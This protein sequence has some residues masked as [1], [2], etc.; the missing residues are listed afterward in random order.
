MTQMAEHIR[1]ACR[2]GFRIDDDTWRYLENTLPDPTPSAVAAI[3]DDAED[4]ESHSLLE[5]LFFPDE[6]M[7]LYVE[8][9]IE[10]TAMTLQ[11]QSDLIDL[12]A[13]EP[14][15]T[16]LYFQAHEKTIYL[17]MPESA[18]PQFVIRL[19]LTYRLHPQLIQSIEQFLPESIGNQ[20]KVRLRNADTAFSAPQANLLAEIFRVLNHRLPDY[21]QCIE[22]ML[23]ILPEM[24][25]QTSAYDF[26]MNQKKYYF[27]CV[28]KAEKF[29]ERLHHSNMETLMMQGERAAHIHPGHGR[30]AM[31][32]I[33]QICRALFGH[34][35]YFHSPVKEEIEINPSKS[36]NALPRI[37]DRLS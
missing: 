4:C 23:A 19:N 36:G 9:M 22:F 31:R 7:Q 32:W 15:C 2:N 12:L 25:S 37:I 10:K 33:D 11:D 26:L 6:C 27:Q 3:L 5:L 18:L 17:T 13:A 16:A 30:R 29:M 8:P 35:D 20:A 14:V 1:T 28:Q 34:S 21:W 24:P